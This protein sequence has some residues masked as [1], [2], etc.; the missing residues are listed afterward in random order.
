MALTVDGGQ[1]SSLPA[2]LIDRMNVTL[3]NAGNTT[4]MPGSTD[5]SGTVSTPDGDIAFYGLEVLR[6]TA[7]A[8]GADRL[9]ANG[10]NGADQITLL[11][12]GTGA[13]QSNRIWVNNQT[14][15]E[16]ANYETV[17]LVGRFSEDRFSVT[18]V[19]V[20][21]ETTT[22]N[23]DGGDPTASD[24]LVVSASAA[25]ETI[26]YAPTASDA[27]SVTV[28][29]SPVVNF[30]TT[31]SVVI[32]G[33]GGNDLLDVLT[34]AGANTI[35][36]TPGAQVDAGGVLVDSLAP[37]SFEGLGATG[38]LRFSDVSAGRVDTLVHRGSDVA[39]TFVVPGAGNI[40]L[41]EH[42][43]HARGGGDAG[44]RRAGAGR[45]W[46]ATICSA[47]RARCRT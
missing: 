13:N 33:R 15:I 26:T 40:T 11:N 43:G 7:P 9:F 19:G 20:A 44:H 12:N 35:T 8:G 14:V 31:E 36:Y 46:R 28:A 17:D 4:S 18:P 5:D 41:D 34:P 42:A 3:T 38:T 1:P 6:L 27:G 10:T 21:N 47:C 25:T 24:L 45:R 39:D 30:A 22:I 2:Q 32:D 37:L 16:F 23:V 29:G